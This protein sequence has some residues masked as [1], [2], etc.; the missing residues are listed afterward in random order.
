MNVGPDV[1]GGFAVG[2]SCVCHWLVLCLFF[3]LVLKLSVLELGALV[4]LAYVIRTGDVD[5]LTAEKEYLRAIWPA[6]HVGDAYEE[7]NRQAH[8][9]YKNAI[10]GTEGW[11]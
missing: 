3:W 11:A 7:D 4:P 9:L 5:P 8:R 10:V 6:P 1:L 2:W